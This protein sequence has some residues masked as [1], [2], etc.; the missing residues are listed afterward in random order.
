MGWFDEQI[1]QRK[2]SDQDIFE[3][4]IFN[5]AASIVGRKGAKTLD[6]RRFVSK[7][8]VEEIIKYFGFKPKAE[9]EDLKDGIKSFGIMYR[10]VE[11]KGRWYKDA[12]GPMLGYVG[13]DKSPVALIPDAAGKYSY[14]DYREKKKVRINSASAKEISEDAFCFYRP[15]PRKSLKIIDLFKY[16]FDCIDNGDIIIFALLTFIYTAIYM[17]FPS[18]SNFISGFVLRSESSKLLFGTAIFLFVAI[19]SSELMKTCSE[20]AE[21][22]FSIKASINVESAVMGRVLNLPPSFFKQYTA[23]EL[24]ARISAVNSLCNILVEQVV[25]I[26]ITT[27]ISFMYL[28]QIGNYASQLVIPSVII[29]ALTMLVTVS[30][31][32]IQSR[33]TSK[34]MKYTAHEDGVSY[35][36]I[37]GIQKIKLSGAEKRAFAK[38]AND[39]TESAN[40]LYNPP[41]FIKINSSIN[42]AITIIGSIVLYYIAVQSGVRPSEYIAFTTA[43]GFIEGAFSNFSS[44]AFSVANIKPILELAEP[45]LKT[46]PENMGDKQLVNKLN[47]GIE[48]NNISFRYNEDGPMILDG[49]NLKVKP[50]EYLAIVGKTGCGKSTIIRLLLGF[51]EPQKGAIYYDSKDI[52]RLDHRS[53]RRKIGTVTQNGTLFQGDIY[54]N[55]V[56]SDPTLSVDAAWEAAEIAGIAED[57]RQMPMGMFTMISEGQGGI[58]GGQKQRIMIARAVAP[59]PKILFMDEAT[60]ALD[61]ITQK[62]VS[63]A[64]DNLKCTRI[65]IAHR[66]STIKNCDRI[67]VLD[68][69]KIVEDGKYDELIAKGGYFTELVK[70]QQ[71]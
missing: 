48:L 47:G 51:E 52:T 46:E 60:S 32:V 56:I 11:L 62:R 61:N 50:G 49:L 71:V 14:Y 30:T 55:I 9:M 70:R 69:G 2:Q 41:L 66:L 40:L 12:Y 19:I 16:L 6:D 36:L 28:L 20:L 25:A 67:V 53:L 54:S 58:S 26:P 39:Y 35:A 18:I 7:K 4:S 3:D 64:L 17:I 37:N 57:I 22:R 15:L 34:V 24:S 44:I 10:K 33:I 29:L 5:M 68:G 21:Q 43:F 1:R 59:K 65:I 63:E 45:I 42:M 23:G 27:V 13:E 38:W 8:A 31:I